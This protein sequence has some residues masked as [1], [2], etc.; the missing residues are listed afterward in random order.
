VGIGPGFGPAHE[1]AWNE[2]VEQIDAE[3][4]KAGAAL[5]GSWEVG[6]AELGRVVVGDPEDARLVERFS[7]ALV[8]T[9]APFTN[10]HKGCSAAMQRGLRAGLAAGRIDVA[11]AP[12][13]Q[14]V[15]GLGPEVDAGWPKTRAYLDP[16]LSRCADPKGA[17]A[18]FDA[19]GP[20]LAGAALE[21]AA[22]LR[23]RLAALPQAPSLY[24]GMTDAVEDWQQ[25]LGRSVEMIVV[26]RAKALVGEVRA[27][28][29]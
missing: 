14:L 3:F 12:L 21:A 8:P 19:G 23:A 15:D 10:L 5:V 29:G 9:Q 22:L 7:D 26:G 18:R 25:A 4:K 1:E 27:G 20:A 13:Q 16:I 2:L 6:A 11:V 28:R 17:A 24:K